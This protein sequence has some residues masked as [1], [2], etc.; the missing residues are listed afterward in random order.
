MRRI[1]VTLLTAAS[2]AFIS[3]GCGAALAQ[4]VS[5]A[6]PYQQGY[7][8]G[9]TE[10]QTNNFSTFD[11]GFRAGQ[12]AQSNSDSGTADI[13]AYNSAEAYDRGFQEG[14][15]RANRDNAQAFN[16]GYVARGLQ[17]RRTSDRAFDEGFDAGVTRHDDDFP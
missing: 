8:A 3:L 4:N 17:D 13:Q 1:H 2:A 10:K 14:I 9:A 11:N 7:A 5:G 12:A 16:Q 15:A 6:D